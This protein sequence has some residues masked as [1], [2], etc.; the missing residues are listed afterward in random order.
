MVASTA[1]EYPL[2]TFCRFR[3]LARNIKITSWD[4]PNPYAE[5]G[6][7]HGKPQAEYSNEILC[8]GGR[9]AAYRTEDA[10]TPHAAVWRI[11]SENGNKQMSQT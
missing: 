1:S 2:A 3:S 6:G 9:K 11:P 5:I 7:G 4:I 8:D 10:A